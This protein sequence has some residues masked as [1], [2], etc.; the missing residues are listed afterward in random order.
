MLP[1]SGSWRPVPDATPGSRTFA[2]PAEWDGVA[3]IATAVA[4]DDQIDLYP[5]PGHRLEI[6]L[7][8]WNALVPVLTVAA[9]TR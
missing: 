6:P 3:V 9:H 1:P 4:H 2:F 8:T 5:V 7:R